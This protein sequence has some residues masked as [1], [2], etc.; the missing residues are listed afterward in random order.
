MDN[1]DEARNILQD[2]WSAGWCPEID[3]IVKR[4][5]EIYEVDVDVSIVDYEPEYSIRSVTLL[6]VRDWCS[7]QNLEWIQVSEMYEIHDY[8]DDMCVGCGEAT[9]GSRG[10]VSVSRL[11]DGR[12]E[13]LATFHDSNPFHK[14]QID[15]RDI[16]VRSTHGTLWRFPLEQPERLAIAPRT[17]P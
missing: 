11:G 16:V 2:R 7:E 12:L 10:F 15:D 17:R 4:T 3:G 14:C 5:G 9:D 1:R 13:W 6:R 8:V